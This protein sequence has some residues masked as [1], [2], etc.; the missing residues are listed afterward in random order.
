[1]WFIL[2]NLRTGQTKAKIYQFTVSLLII[3][4]RVGEVGNCDLHRDELVLKY[5]L[6]IGNVNDGVFKIC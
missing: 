3:S 4:V 5:I 2:L 6:Y 1:M